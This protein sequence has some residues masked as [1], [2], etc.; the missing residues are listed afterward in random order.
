MKKIVI[1]RTA[2]RK[3]ETFFP[4][5]YENEIRKRPGEVR[6]GEL[7]EIYSLSNEFLGTGYFN[8]QSVI[9]V[10]MLSFDREPVNKDL[11]RKR[12]LKAAVFRQKI[13]KNTNAY[14][15]IH[16]EADEL[17]GLIVDY[18][19]GYLAL[20]INTA[21]MENWR[22]AIIE[23]LV[24][25]LHPK[26][27]Y[28]KSDERSRMLEGIETS[29][30]VIHGTLPEKILIT[31]N[32][33]R[34]SVRLKD[35][36]KTGFYLDQRKNRAAVSRYV[37]KGFSVLDVFSNTGGFGIYAAIR[38]ADRVRLVDISQSALEQAR[39]NA[40]LNGLEKIETIRADAFDFLTELPG[41]ADRFDMIVL[42]PPSFT[43]T[44]QGKIGALKG[45]RHLVLNSLRILK[46]GGYLAVF[47][48]SHHVSMEDL[49]NALL[50][51]SGQS[52]VRLDIQEHLFQD[53]DHPVILNV[54]QSLY[55]KGLLLKAC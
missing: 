35:S 29:E 16:S 42:D 47:S 46:P 4:W 30:K 34:F 45:F 25:V 18:Y 9:C 12:I 40:A 31:E 5:I 27:I 1:S 39:E 24:E 19:D 17:P 6:R 20:Q 50:E 37:E 54:P 28:E 55:L 21:G 41:S 36:Q 53:L 23:S 2:D 51:V 11:F 33:V 22:E 43:K 7:V 10:R 3:I 15:I 26:G 8:P 48:C 44:K 49:K 38:G 14:R 13:I 32:G 52:R